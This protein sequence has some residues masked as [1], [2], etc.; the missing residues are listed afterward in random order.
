MNAYNQVNGSYCSENH[1]LLTK[2]LKEE[3]KHEG[4]VLTDW[5]ATNDRIEGLKAGMELE[6]PGS[7]GMND[8][9]IVQAVKKG[10]LSEAVLDNRVLSILNLIFKAEETL[11]DKYSYDKSNHHKLAGKAAAESMVLLKN[12]NKRLPLQ[13]SGTVAFIGSFA[14]TP[15]YQ[16]AGSSQINPT[17]IDTALE[18]ARDFADELN[19]IY[20]EGFN[21]ESDEISKELISE[22]VK[23]AESADQT[24]IFAELPSHFE[25]EGFDRK[26][27]RLPENQLALIDAVLEK[28]PHAVIVLANGSPVEM[29]F[30]DNCE[31][32]LEGY[33]GGQAGG[34]AIADILF[35]KQTP[36][37]KIAETF[38]LC[39]ED[40]P[41]NRYFPGNQKQVLYKEG[42]YVGYRYFDRA[43]KK[44]LFPFGHGLSYTTFEYSNLTLS[45][46]IINEKEKLKVS[47]TIKNTG[48]LEG[49]EIVQLYVRDVVSSVYRPLKEL[50]GFEKIGLQPG[51]SKDVS[52]TLNKRSFAF[53]DVNSGNWQVESGDFE[54]LIGSSSRDLRL[55]KT[56][57]VN[58]SFKT[59]ESPRDKI[60]KSLIEDIH[61]ISTADFESLLGKRLPLPE[62]IK[63]FSRTSTIADVKTTFIGRRL[64]PF[65]KQGFLSKFGDM[66]KSTSLMVESIVKEM[67]LKSFAYMGGEKFSNNKL[68]GIIFILNGK[69]LRGLLTFIK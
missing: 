21:S 45:D 5:G 18:S 13:A 1:K 31:A 29:P 65:I 59:K 69:F 67:P 58:S 15:R 33:L 6:M 40:I 7:N 62:P 41:S 64:E 47:C 14:K 28:I 43:E 54:I 44:V 30:I 56:A 34:G 37:G 63:P 35:G 61:N 48:D 50:K 39:L 4:I 9:K 52:F 10:D 17:Q 66:N 51:E 24:V 32:I 60:Y 3:W 22:A 49:K 46:S 26:H 16:G 2:I 53:Y 42:L 11:S 27:M 55:R 8:E 12:E 57:T 25:S 38:P 36:C 68:E 19:V 20:A 23:V